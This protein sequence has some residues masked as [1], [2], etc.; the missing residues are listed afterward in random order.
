MKF[1]DL[2]YKRYSNPEQLLNQMILTDSFDD[3]IIE[4]VT[5]HNKE[6]NEKVNWEFYL[7]R[8]F[9]RSFNDF[10]NGQEEN[11]SAGTHEP[12]KDELEATVQ[13]SMELL[14]GFNLK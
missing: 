3:F 7:H 6:V 5:M 8:V 14:K 2:L 12:T 10:I 1:W 11:D 13:S 9:D 4:L